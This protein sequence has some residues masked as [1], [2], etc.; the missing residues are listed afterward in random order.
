[1]FPCSNPLEEVIRYRNSLAEL[2]IARG[3]EIPVLH[4]AVRADRVLRLMQ[5]FNDVDTKPNSQEISSDS[6]V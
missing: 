3:V 6:K 2:Y 1:M 4:V 5:A